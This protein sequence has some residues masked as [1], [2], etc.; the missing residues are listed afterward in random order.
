MEHLKT[1]KS[2]HHGADCG[3]QDRSPDLPEQ[4]PDS[5]ERKDVRREH[6]EIERSRQRQEAIE[7]QVERVIGAQLAFSVKVEAVEHL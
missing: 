2:E 6:L 1:R 7:E 3:G 4:Q 5:C